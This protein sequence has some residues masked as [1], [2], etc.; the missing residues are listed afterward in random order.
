MGRFLYFFAGITFL[1]GFVGGEP[2][3]KSST[4]KFNFGI[5]I[6]NST[7]VHKFWLKSTGTDTVKIRKLETTCSC[8]TM[9]LAR[10][11]IAPGDSLEVTISWDTQ[12]TFGPVNR[13]PRIYYEGAEEPLRI[14]LSTDVQYAPDSMLPLSIWPFKFEL[15]R[16]PVK[17]VDSL[18]F[19]I[20]NTTAKDIEVSI[21]SHVLEQ[22]EIYL[23][24]V[25]PAYS[26]A[27]GFIKIKLEFID[28]EFENSITVR[29]SHD[30]KYFIT[31]PIRRKVYMDSSG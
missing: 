27:F 6:N 3:L 29:S 2:V 11:E 12:R 24:K 13:Y 30:K 22:C 10:N 8:T 19:R 26:A 5:S 16:H 21:V 15:G 25:I 4:E 9:P 23:P 18:E 31:V 20:K 17:S 14:G 1:S 28:Q 7:I